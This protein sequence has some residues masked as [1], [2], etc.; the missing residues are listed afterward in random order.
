MRRRGFLQ[1]VAGTVAWPIAARRS[2]RCRSSGCS[3]AAR[4]SRAA[5][6]STASIAGS[7]GRLRGGRQRRRQPARRGGRL[8]PV[9][10][11]RRA[12]S[13]A[14][15]RHR[16]DRRSGRGGSPP[17]TPPARSRSCS[18]PSPSR[19]A[20][21]WSP[22]S[23]APADVTGSAG[24][25]R[26]STRSGWRSCWS[27]CRAATVGALLNPNRPGVDTQES[28]M[29]AAATAADAAAAFAPAP[30]RRSKG[31]AAMAARGRTALAVGADPFFANHRRQLVALAARHGLP[32]CTNGANSSRRVGSSAT[33]PTSRRPTGCQAPM[34]DALQ[35][36]RPATCPSSSPPSNLYST[37]APRKPPGSTLPPAL[38]ARADGR[39]ASRG[40][41]RRPPPAIAAPPSPSARDRPGRSRLADWARRRPAGTRRSG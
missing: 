22:A 25:P 36:R 31:F 7:A 2:R 30:A 29:R 11:G 1:L 37:S 34:W 32:P 20:S 5:T 19:S 3:T 40:R 6:R 9:R 35:A 39:R 41:E 15:Q 13:P 23:T 38:S 12:R 27:S 16:R 10:A 33:A 4:G 24:S 17:R 21:D 28:D 14:R 8:Q 18:P 26:S